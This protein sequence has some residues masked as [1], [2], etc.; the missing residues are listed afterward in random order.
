MKRDLKR[1]YRQS[2]IKNFALPVLVALGLAAFADRALNGYFDHR[3]EAAELSETLEANAAL[4]A[5][6]SKL[7]KNFDALS[8][9]FTATRKRLLT[10]EDRTQAG[11]ELQDQVQKLLQ[12]LYFDGISVFDLSE[13]AEGG[14]TMVSTGARFFGVPQQLP[15]LEAA[16]AQSPVLLGVESLEIKVVDD[17]QRGGKQLEITARFSSVHISEA[18]AL[19]PAPEKTE[20]KRES[21]AGK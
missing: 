11:K 19:A 6:G 13:V 16:I 20:N 15:R 10:A 8:T 3:Q 5:L 14:A 4:L 18:K 12:S 7:Q 2:G 1:V 21:T 9:D 17:T